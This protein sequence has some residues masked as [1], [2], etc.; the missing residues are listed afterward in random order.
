MEICVDEYADAPDGVPVWCVEQS[1]G[2]E[3]ILQLIGEI[4]LLAILFWLS[5]TFFR[6][7]RR[8]KAQKEWE[9]EQLN[10]S[11]NDNRVWHP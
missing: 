3:V 5:T 6:F 4:C 7:L 2:A 10:K 1:F 9:R 8:R 11:E